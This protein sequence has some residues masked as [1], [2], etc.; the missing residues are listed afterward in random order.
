M[1]DGNKDRRG[2][3]TTQGQKEINRKEIDKKRDRNNQR[4]IQGKKK[5]TKETL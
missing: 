1:I 4:K 5:T 3:R 2:R